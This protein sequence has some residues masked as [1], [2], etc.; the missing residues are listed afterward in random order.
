MEKT[1][2]LSIAIEHYGDGMR[3]GEAAGRHL[4]HARLIQLLKKHGHY[5]A[6]LTINAHAPKSSVTQRPT[7]VSYS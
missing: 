3:R 2:E 4:E 5:D 7:V 1:I 6:I